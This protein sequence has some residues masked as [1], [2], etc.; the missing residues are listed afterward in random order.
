[1][2]HTVHDMNDTIPY[3]RINVFAGHFGSGKTE[4]AVNFALYL[5]RKGKKTAIVDLDIVN[6]FFRTKDAQDALEQEGIKVIS[7]LYA[8]TNVDVPA[9][10]PGVY[11]IFE[12]RS[13]HVVLDIGGDDLGAKAISRFREELLEEEFALFFVVNPLRPFTDTAEKMS[14][15][16]EEVEHSARVRF[17]G[18]VNNTN[19][20]QLTTKDDLLTGRAMVETFASNSQIP[21]AF[22]SCMKGMDQI[23]ISYPRLILDKYVKVVWD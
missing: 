17:T 15:M 23:P 11:S 7:S 16:L 10:S 13:Y 8:N 5:A 14:Q 22:E 6:P 21:I 9:V 20:M 4:V 12:D 19:L 1:M 3:K 18:I 2:Q